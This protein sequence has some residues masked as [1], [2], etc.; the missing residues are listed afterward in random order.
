MRY[1]PRV[2]SLLGST[3]VYRSVIDRSTCSHP[4][5]KGPNGLKI[6][7][8]V[9]HPSDAAL[10]S[11]RSS[12][13]QIVCSPLATLESVPR[14]SGH[15]PDRRG[16]PRPKFEL[17]PVNNLPRPADCERRGDR[18][19]SNTRRRTRLGPRC[20]S[21]CAMVEC[22]SETELMMLTFWDQPGRKT[23][24][25]WLSSFWKRQFILVL[26]PCLIV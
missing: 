18:P 16:L 23:V 15:L 9:N 11:K 26:L 5:P 22:P 17:V 1:Y 19:L 7:Y 3:C 12:H 25:R 6:S 8:G 24:D 21:G 14:S 2:S 13:P 20:S 10:Q 4:S